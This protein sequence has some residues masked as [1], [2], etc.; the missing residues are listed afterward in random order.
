MEACGE[1]PD[2]DYTQLSDEDI[3]RM[4]RRGLSLRVTRG[5]AFIVWSL[6]ATHIDT[7]RAPASAN[8]GNVQRSATH[9]V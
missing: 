7:A 8:Y 1:D 9:C 2:P 4:T 6:S 5:D 3:E